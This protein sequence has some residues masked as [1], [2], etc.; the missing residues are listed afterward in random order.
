[1]DQPETPAAQPDPEVTPLNPFGA[2]RTRT[3]IPWMIVVPPV[4]YLLFL[5]VGRL[6][7]VDP[8]DIM[9]GNIATM[10]IGYGA[11]ALWIWWACRRSGVGL[12]RL[13]GSVPAGHNWL[14]TAGILA[15]ALAFSMGAWDVFASTLS[16]AAPGLLEWMIEAL[17]DMDTPPGTSLVTTLVWYAGLV[18]VAPAL[19]EV[20]F[21]GVLINRW[22]V[23]WGVGRAVIVSSVLFAFLHANVIGIFVFG[24]IAALLYL[25][26]RTLLVPI[27]FH[28]A[29]NLVATLSGAVFDWE[30]MMEV[31]QIRARLYLGIGLVVVSL[32]VL[33]RYMMRNWPG[34][35]GR[36]PY[37]AAE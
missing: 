27:A 14:P 13:V 30:N 12:R 31:E 29:N 37:T 22:G 3:L 16:H 34:R 10:T 5:L 24:M 21:R 1:M 32:P 33:V 28:A 4:L 15:L 18:L 7:V 11:L 23:K 2:L 19:E 26:T 6:G 20:L 8:G 9:T 36:V 17:S 35:E 25:R